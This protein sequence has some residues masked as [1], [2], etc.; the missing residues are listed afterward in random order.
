MNDKEFALLAKG[1][2]QY[3]ERDKVFIKNP[4]RFAEVEN[5]YVIAKKLFADSVVTIE[6]DPIQMG[7]LILDIKGYDIV[8]RGQEEI[9]LFSEMISKADNFEMYPI[10]NEKICFALVFSRALARMS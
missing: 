5:A 6:D 4:E 7:A 10:D 9:A 2:Q 8:I 3:L 1:L